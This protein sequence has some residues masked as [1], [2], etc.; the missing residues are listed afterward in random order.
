MVSIDK[1]LSVLKISAGGDYSCAITTSN[2]LLV[3]GSNSCCQLG[4]GKEMTEACVPILF[5]GKIEV[6][7]QEEEKGDEITE[8]FNFVDV[9]CGSSQTLAI[10]DTSPFLIS[11]GNGDPLAKTYSSIFEYD[12]PVSYDC[13]G[14]RAVFLTE[15]GKVYRLNLKSKQFKEVKGLQ[16]D[17]DVEMADHESD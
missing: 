16:E 6:A 8:R 17:R 14:K 3:W 15:K 7:T 1:E 11:W 13:D 9:V 12:R 2:Q 4:Y 10:I 5:G